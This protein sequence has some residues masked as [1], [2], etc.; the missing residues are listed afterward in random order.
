MHSDNRRVLTA[1]GAAKFLGISLATLRK[2]ER[3]GELLPSR[4]PG[5]HRRYSVAMLAEY[6]EKS[7]RVT[8]G[9]REPPPQPNRE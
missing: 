5:G 7:R 3:S 4:T 6:F 9:P 1:R 8:S 2:I